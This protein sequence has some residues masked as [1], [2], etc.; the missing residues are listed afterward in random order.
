[1]VSPPRAPRSLALSGRLLCAS[2]ANR[3]DRTCMRASADRSGFRCGTSEN[4]PKLGEPSARKTNA[5]ALR[6]PTDSRLGMLAASGFRQ[7]I[8]RPWS[9]KF[10]G[11]RCS[12]TLTWKTLNQ[13]DRA[14]FPSSRTGSS[15]ICRRRP[16]LASVP[17]RYTGGRPT[18]PKSLD[19]QY[20]HRF[21]RPSLRHP[22]TRS[23]RGSRTGRA[24]SPGY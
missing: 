3:L 16:G 7:K 2:S 21:D 15:L 14:R 8:D 13:S 6:T 4:E 1:M 5:N 20:L 19:A 24:G 17:V 22:G 10:T 9:I 18:N 23:G 12:F 11:K